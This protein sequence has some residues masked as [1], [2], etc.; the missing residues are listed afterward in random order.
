MISVNREEEMLRMIAQGR[1]D[2]QISKDLLLSIST[3]RKY[4]EMLLGKFGLKKSSQLVA[5]YL[6]NNRYLIK[7]RKPTALFLRVN[8]K[9][10]SIS[11]MDLLTSR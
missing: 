1:T 9:F 6:S 4:R 10:L 8:C 2:R 11:L 5:I 7:K 3:T